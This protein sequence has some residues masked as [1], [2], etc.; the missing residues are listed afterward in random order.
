MMFKKK[1]TSLLLILSIHNE[2][3]NVNCT[4]KMQMCY[5]IRL[6]VHPKIISISGVTM[7]VFSSVDKIV[8]VVGGA[9]RSIE[10]IESTLLSISA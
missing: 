8:L 2:N 3:S 6:D 5:P 1:R 10:S 9:S 4:Q 7:Y